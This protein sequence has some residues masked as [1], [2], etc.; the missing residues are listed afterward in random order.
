MRASR[1]AAMS[2]DPARSRS[3]IAPART[4][5]WIQACEFGGAQGPPQP[6]RLVAGFPAVAGRQGVHEQ[7][8]VPVV[9]GRDGLGGPDRVQ[10]GQVV[11]I[12]EGLMADLG[13][14]VLLAVASEHAGQARSAPPLM[15]GRRWPPGRRGRRRGGR[16]G[17]VRG[18][19]A[20]RGPGRRSWARR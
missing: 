19:G 18:P 15:S 14:G 8:A 7:V 17:P 6:I 13:G 2:R 12:G 4:R 3:A 1:T 20:G 9:P 16:S 10:D 11:H 5:A